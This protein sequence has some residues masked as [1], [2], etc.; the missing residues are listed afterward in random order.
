MVIVL[1]T[2]YT[3][4]EVRELVDHIESKGVHSFGKADLKKNLQK[5]P[6]ILTLQSSSTAECLKKILRAVL[7]MPQCSAQRELS[8][9]V[10]VTR[11]LTD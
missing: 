9:K 5:K 1:N 2:G 11:L 10:K 6:M 7:H 3:Q 4:D 8:K